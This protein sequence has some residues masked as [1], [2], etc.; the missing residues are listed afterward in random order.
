[1]IFKKTN[2]SSKEKY[3]ANIEKEGTINLNTDESGAVDIFIWDKNGF[4]MLL[5]PDQ[6]P[7]LVELIEN[8]H[9]PEPKKQKGVVD[10]DFVLDLIKGIRIDAKNIK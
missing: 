3:N 8:G 6:Y 2:H 5:P 9:V 4:S 1:M 10:Q 7:S